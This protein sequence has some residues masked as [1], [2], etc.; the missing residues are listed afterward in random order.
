MSRTSLLILTALLAAMSL[1]SCHNSSPLATGAPD[2]AK[3]EVSGTEDNPPPIEHVFLI[4]LENKGF[5]ETYGPGSPAVYLRD[6]LA[7]QGQLMRQ[8]HGVA[9]A[10]TGNYIALVS[11]QAP[12]VNIQADCA[13]FT[14][15]IR[16]GMAPYGQAIGLGCVFP[17]DIPNIADDLEG[18]GLSWKAYQEDMAKEKSGGAGSGDGACVYPDIGTIDATNGADQEEQYATRHNPFMF[19]H[20]V[21]DNPERCQ[22]NDVDLELMR[23]DLQSRATTPNYAFITPDN[24]HNAHDAEC[25]DGGAGGLE[26]TNEF[27]EEWV[28]LIL[29]SPAYKES[30]MLVILFDEDDLSIPAEACCGQAENPGPNTL[31]PGIFGPGGGRFGAVVLSKF[32]TPGSINDTPYNHYSLL[33][34]VENI[35]GL[36]ANGYLGFAG[37]EHP[38]MKAF[39]EDVYS[40]GG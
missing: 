14:D 3:C 39:G 2:P 17:A 30:G 19:F 22:A 4:L 34:S 21:L 10:S 1:A 27:L 37:L 13:I 8:F 38:Q 5:D 11:G 25:S 15:F 18:A 16:L 24:C 26:R 12:N 28:P 36:D 29:N 33:R 9:H 23:E 6:V 32:T 31:T 35:F 40:C 7:P 20:S